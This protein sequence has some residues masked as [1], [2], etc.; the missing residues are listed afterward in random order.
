MA[1]AVTYENFIVETH[2]DEND[3]IVE[4][5]VFHEY[6]EDTGTIESTNTL[7]DG[8]RLLFELIA[9]Q[10][11]QINTNQSIEGQSGY[12][13]YLL[14][15]QVVWGDSPEAEITITSEDAYTVNPRTRADKPLYVTYTMKNLV[16]L[17]DEMTDVK[18]SKA[19]H[20]YKHGSTVIEIETV[21]ENLTKELVQYW[22]MDLITNKGDVYNTFGKVYF[23][24]LEFAD[25]STYSQ[26]DYD[27][28]RVRVLR[29]FTGS[30]TGVEEGETY[31]VL[32]TMSCTVVNSYPASECR[33]LVFDRKFAVSEL[34]IGEEFITAYT[35][36]ATITTAQNLGNSSLTQ[37]FS[38][39]LAEDIVTSDGDWTLAFVH[40]TDQ[41]G[42]ELIDYK[43]FKYKT[44]LEVRSNISTS[45]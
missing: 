1:H 25:D 30:L 15:E 26:S 40:T 23:S 21:D 32:P 16:P 36:V 3:E 14:G 44:T 24:M 12:V 33:I 18:M 45:N 9:I 2:Y 17:T 35:P 10:T 11:D 31:N 34:A 38:R 28:A 37:E 22:P 19:L 29:K 6:L 27:S 42:D 41:W 20:V 13:E 5:L 8:H 4:P 43:R 7:E 39:T